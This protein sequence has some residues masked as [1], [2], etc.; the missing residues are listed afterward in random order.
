M[1]N[2]VVAKA[3]RQICAIAPPCLEESAELNAQDPH[4]RVCPWRDKLRDAQRIARA[5][6]KE[7]GE[8]ERD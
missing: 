1:A 5:C 3:L 2:E 6:L 7:I 4:E 8:S